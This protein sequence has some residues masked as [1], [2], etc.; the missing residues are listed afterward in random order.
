MHEK[1]DGGVDEGCREVVRQVG[2]WAAG[3]GWGSRAR[4]G[5]YDT[6]ECCEGRKRCVAQC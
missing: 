6:E 2:V 1:T 4:E 5:E 3:W